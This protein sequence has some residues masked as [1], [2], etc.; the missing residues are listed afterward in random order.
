V[1]SVPITSVYKYHVA[2]FTLYFLFNLIIKKWCHDE[3]EHADMKY[4]E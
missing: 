3:H 1:L 4:A 2:S